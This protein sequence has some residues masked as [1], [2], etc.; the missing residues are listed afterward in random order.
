M[1]T[2]DAQWC[3]ALW[4]G[5]VEALCWL[6]RSLLALLLALVAWTSLAEGFLVH[7]NAFQAQI[8]SACL[9]G[10]GSVFGLSRLGDRAPILLQRGGSGVQEG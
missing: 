6:D 2:G 7:L 8:C 5:G 9:H 4:V 10:Q 1:V 3:G